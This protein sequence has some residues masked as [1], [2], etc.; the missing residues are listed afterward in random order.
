MS[1]ARA[2][3]HRVSILPLLV[4]ALAA[5]G[6]APGRHTV[7][8]RTADGQVRTTTPGPRPPV[9]IPKEEIQQAVRALARKVVPAADPL[10]YARQRFDIPIRG[11]VYV[12]NL[13]TQQI[14]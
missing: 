13:R 10:E 11:G 8:L 12:Y 9:A 4:I 3:V 14:R 7:R 6:C 1:E 5:V 2:T